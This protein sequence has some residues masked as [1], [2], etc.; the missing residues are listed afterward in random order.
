MEQWYVDLLKKQEKD[1][2]Y[3]KE[4]TMIMMDEFDIAQKRIFEL[5]SAIQRA[6]DI[7]AMDDL[8]IDEFESLLQKGAE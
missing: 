7:H 4:Y 6:V 3:W 2:E 5:E 1:P 8:V